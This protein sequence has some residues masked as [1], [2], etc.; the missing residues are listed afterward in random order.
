MPEIPRSM[1]IDPPGEGDRTA[2]GVIIVGESLLQKAHEISQQVEER[3]QRVTG[4]I[5]PQDEPEWLY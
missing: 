3:H 4:Y 5:L 1:R 2:H